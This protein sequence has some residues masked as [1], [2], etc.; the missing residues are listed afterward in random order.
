MLRRSKGEEKMKY[1]FD[2]HICDVHFL[3]SRAGK[4]KSGGRQ[5]HAAFILF[6]THDL[7]Q[8]ILNSMS[9]PAARERRERVLVVCAAGCPSH[10]VL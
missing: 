8:S 6:R 7:Y 4:W 3:I 9:T 5:E 2:P 1:A 10:Y